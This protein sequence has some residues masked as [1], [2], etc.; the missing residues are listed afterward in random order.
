MKKLI[1][2]IIYSICLLNLCL[3]STAQEQ[4]NSK[5][6]WNALYQSLVNAYGFDQVLVNGIGYED[7]YRGSVGHPF[8]YEQ[9]NKGSLVFREREYQGVD[10]KYDIHKQ[11]VIL[12]V[13]QNNLNTWIIPP[14]DFISAF[15]IGDQLFVKYTFQ[16][17]PG[18]YQAIFDA[19]ELKCLYYWSKLRYDSDHNKDY[20]SFRFTDSRR[21]TYLFTGGVL[22][23][24]SNNSSFVRLFPQESQGRIKQYIKNN[25]INVTNSSDVDMEKL[26]TYCKTLL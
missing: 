19:E 2:L 10:I 14:N 11:R 4:T 13:R 8:L 12:Y 23:K 16:G 20:N 26:V 25:K 22:K 9:F 7:E 17:V 5:T 1:Y 21:K 6:Y 3:F 18:F 24:Y 15:H